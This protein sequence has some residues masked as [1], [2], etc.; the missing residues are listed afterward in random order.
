MIANGLKITAD[1]LREH[2][3]V[4]AITT[5]VV[6]KPP[7]ERSTPWVMVQLLSA[8]QPPNSRTDHLVE[9]YFQIDCYAGARGG[10]PEAVSL[11]QT[12]RQALFD[13]P[14]VDHEDAVTT[15]T[16]IRGY[17]YLPDPSFEPARDRAIIT[18]SVWIH[19]SPVAA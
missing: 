7:E 12:V 19:P 14:D 17:R 8:P 6:T 16:R 13:M 3:D 11:G 1:Y 2:A 5:R 4:M 18:A 9:F 15:A 10:I